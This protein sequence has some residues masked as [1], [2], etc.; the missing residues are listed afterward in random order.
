MPEKSEL[1]FVTHMLTGIR[2]QA[3]SLN[4]RTG[5]SD[6]NTLEISNLAH[7]LDTYV[8]RLEREVARLEAAPKKRKLFRRK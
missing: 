2:D 7:R 3:M 5:L 6:P 1:K 8:G 4:E